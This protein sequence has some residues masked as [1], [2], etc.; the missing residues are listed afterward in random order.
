MPACADIAGLDRVHERI[1]DERVVQSAA[2]TLCP[3]NAER[4][5][6]AVLACILVTS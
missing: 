4:S 3:V 1:T 6:R 2:E 5:A